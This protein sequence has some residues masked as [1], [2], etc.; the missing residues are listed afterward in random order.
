MIVW[1]GT[2][3]NYYGRPDYLNT[4]GRYDPATDSWT[5]LGGALSARIG[6]TAVWTGT[7]MIIWGG[8]RYTGGF[9]IYNNGGR[10]DPATNTWTATNE[11]EAP[12][13]RTGHTAVWTGTKMIVWGGVGSSPSDSF[14]TGSRYDPATDTW[15]ATSLANVPSAR[16]GHTAVW[17][18]TEMIVWGPGNTGGRYDPVTDTWTATNTASAPSARSGHT[19]VWTGT[20]MIVWGGGGS[21]TG[22]RYDPVTDTWIATNTASAPSARSGHTAVWTGTEM[23]VWGGVGSGFPYGSNTGGRYDPDTN[24]WAATNTVNAPIPR[25]EHTAVWTGTEMIIWGG[26]YGGYLNTG[27][28]YCAS[29]GSGG[30]ALQ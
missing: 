17:T 2:Y 26:L 15:E 21:N 22:G 4:G 18:D 5:N 1:G 6:H 9:A 11:I 27:G 23:I 3:I 28:R 10:Y 7:K 16:S 25:T 20:E 29:A 14:S 13:A 19:V 8:H 24:T 30:P 12:R